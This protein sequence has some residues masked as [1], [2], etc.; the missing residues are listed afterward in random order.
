[1]ANKLK[2]I[3]SNKMTNFE[4]T[5]RFENP[6]AFKKYL[7]ALKIVEEEGRVVEV[8]GVS[9]I[10][11]KVQNGSCKYPFSEINKLS[12]VYISPSIEE[13]PITLQTEMGEK[14][15]QL[16]RYHTTKETILETDKN[17]VVYLKLCFN[18]KSKQNKFSYRVQPELAKTIEEIIESYTTIVAFLNYLFKN[19]AHTP[20]EEYGIIE[21]TKRYFNGAVAYYKRVRKIEE[22]FKVQFNPAE[23]NEKGNDEQELEELYL[24]ICENKAL[25]LNAKLNGP[26]NVE[27]AT[28]EFAAPLEIGK[29]ME[30]TFSSTA[31]YEIY[32]EKI[33]IYTTCL[34][35]NAL[36]QE[37]KE[38]PDGKTKIWYGDIDSE[39]M[40]ISFMGFIT[41]DEKD[42]EIK[43]IMKHK[44]K[45]IEAITVEEYILK[46]YA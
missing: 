18:K 15:F 43:N 8:E 4:G 39:P 24:L 32:G 37:V 19:D 28:T 7:E 42:Q 13:V 17:A 29:K 23:Q 5:I 16:K 20:K 2:D 26:G 31:E 25:R 6:E 30:F 41:T 38:E 34:L 11:T 46:K 9:S 10:S 27:F 22:T 21:K 1:M 40:F 12:K 35:S 14:I 33:S 44:K 36:I 3:F 45:Y